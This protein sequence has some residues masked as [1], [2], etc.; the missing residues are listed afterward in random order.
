MKPTH[1]YGLTIEDYVILAKGRIRM[2]LDA[3]HSREFTSA[4][5]SEHGL[6]IEQALRTT[7]TSRTDQLQFIENWASANCENPGVSAGRAIPR[8]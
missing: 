1:S 7:L 2:T 6:R 3:S 8:P 4:F 5:F